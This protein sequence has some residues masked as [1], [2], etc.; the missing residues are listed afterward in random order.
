MKK[1]V[2]TVPVVEVTKWE[3]EDII[4][5]SGLVQVAPNTI[6]TIGDDHVTATVDYNELS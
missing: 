5:T 1:L 6:S 2:Y 4:T 3:A